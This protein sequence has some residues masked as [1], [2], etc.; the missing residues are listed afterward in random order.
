[1][2]HNI[3]EPM[4]AGIPIITFDVGIASSVI[5]DFTTGFIIKG[6]KESENFKRT[7]RFLLNNERVA[8]QIGEQAKSFAEEWLT[9][10]ITAENCLNLYEQMYI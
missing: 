6:E 4:F 9:W 1:M 10:E 2:G 5:R 8:K 3:L 7:V